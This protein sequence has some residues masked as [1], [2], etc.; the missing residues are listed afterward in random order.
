MYISTHLHTHLYT[1]TCTHIPTH[2]YTYIHTYT[3]IPIH[4]PKHLYPP[5]HAHTQT[6]RGGRLVFCEVSVKNCNL[7]LKPKSKGFISLSILFFVMGA[8]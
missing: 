6:E 1:H 8:S 4:I 2:T 7:N 3:N 5:T